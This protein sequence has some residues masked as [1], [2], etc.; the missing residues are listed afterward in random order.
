MLFGRKKPARKVKKERSKNVP[1]TREQVKALP[2]RKTELIESSPADRT[3]KKPTFKE[4]VITHSGFT[5]S[6]DDQ[7]VSAR[8][9]DRKKLRPNNRKTTPGRQTMIVPIMVHKE[10]KFGIVMQNTGQVRKAYLGNP[11][12]KN[13]AFLRFD[14]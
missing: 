13:Q 8:A 12:I 11:N 10:T 2:V 6:G 14:K 9:S 7:N 1:F 5:S 3:L 4:G